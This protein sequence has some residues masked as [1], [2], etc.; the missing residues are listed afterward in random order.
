MSF[1]SE[2]R[3]GIVFTRVTGELDNLQAIEHLK[4]VRE[5]GAGFDVYRELMDL[6]GVERVTQTSE[7]IKML[8]G[9][10]EPLEMFKKIYLAIFAESE[11]AYGLSRMFQVF[12]ELAENPVEIQVFREKQEALEWLKSR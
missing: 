6:S 5:L 11:L 9:E 7:Q 4:L 1:E 3:E 2:V 10:A 8:A 12:A